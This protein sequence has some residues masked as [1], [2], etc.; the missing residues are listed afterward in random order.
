[1]FSVKRLVYIILIVA[2]I[3]GVFIIYG[4]KEVQSQYVR[5]SSVISEPAEFIEV[6]EAGIKGN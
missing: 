2:A 3:S 1:M 5:T 6:P 4:V